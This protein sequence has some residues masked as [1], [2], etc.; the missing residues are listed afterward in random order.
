MD[1]KTCSKCGE[2]K[3]LSEFGKRKDRPDG[4]QYHCK[5]CKSASN[6]DHY[7]ANAEKVKATTAKRA[8]EKKEEIRVYR[9]K[10]EKENAE[11][12]AARQRARRE[13]MADERAAYHRKYR[14]ENKSTVNALSRA[15]KARKIKRTP[16]WANE[17][18]IRA[19]YEEAA[20]LEQE[21]GIKYHVDHIIPL[22]GE[23]VSG[24]HVENNL[25]VIPANENLSKS[26]HYEVA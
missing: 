3:P 22:Q 21:T 2:E 26:N 12:I 18:V 8:V 16:S 5:A 25:Q 15:Y 1:S 4:L 20:R 7:K 17:Q 9:K 6:S 10:Y 14:Q 23:L 13:E 19:F 11:R 24:L